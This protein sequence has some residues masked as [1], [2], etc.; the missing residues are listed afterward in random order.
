MRDGI[1]SSLTWLISPRELMVLIMWRHC[2]YR[3]MQTVA[4]EGYTSLI[5]CTL[6]R[7]SHLSLNC[8]FRCRLEMPAYGQLVLSY[9][10]FFSCLVH[11]KSRLVLLCFLDKVSPCAFHHAE[12]M[13]MLW[14]EGI[15]F[16]RVGC[17]YLYMYYVQ[18]CL[19][20]SLSMLCLN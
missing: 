2:E 16:T 5:A 17:F 1:K 9:F 8:T 12:I 6:R 20:A 10:F 15:G 7:N 18:F 14:E 19:L 11:V 4:W 3:S 13:K